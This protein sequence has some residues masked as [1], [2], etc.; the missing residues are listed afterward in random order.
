MIILALAAVLA[1]CRE[2][3]FVV[4]GE[5]DPVAMLASG[6]PRVNPRSTIGLFLGRRTRID[7]DSRRPSDLLLSLPPKQGRRTL[8]F[9]RRTRLDL[10]AWDECELEA[11]TQEAQKM[12]GFLIPEFLVNKNSHCHTNQVRLNEICRYPFSSLLY[13]LHPQP[14][15]SLLH[16]QSR[17]V[18]LEY[19]FF[20]VFR[21]SAPDTAELFRLRIV[22]CPLQATLSHCEAQHNVGVYTQ[23]PGLIAIDPS[24]VPLEV[25]SDISK[26]S[27]IDQLPTIV[28]QVV[29]DARVVGFTSFHRLSHPSL[30]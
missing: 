8:F 7:R 28:R 1:G 16:F 2:S 24:F 10:S 5:R 29:P 17:E 26:F 6:I 19:L 4:I 3:V 15:L 12:I 18:K 25:S 14:K 22:F 13:S 30:Q 23:E 27:I 20:E 9:K 11:A 21:K